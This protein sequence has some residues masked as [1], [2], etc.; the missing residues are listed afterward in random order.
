MHEVRSVAADLLCFEVLIKTSFL[1]CFCFVLAL[2]LFYA[3]CIV[4]P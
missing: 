1:F 4:Q 3:F 2:F